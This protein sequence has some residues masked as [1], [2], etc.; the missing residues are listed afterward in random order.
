VRAAPVVVVAVM[1]AASG[2]GLGGT[3]SVTLRARS[4][5]I[6]SDAQP[7][8]L[9][10]ISSG[11]AGE[12][13][14]VQGKECGVPGA[15]FRGIAGAMT[16]EGGGWITDQI[17]QRTTTTYRAVWK[18]S[19]S[20]PLVVRQRINVW[21]IRT[22][23]G[24]QVGVSGEVGNWDRRRVTVQRLTTAGWRRLTSVV[25][26]AQGV[27]SVARRGGLRFSVAKGTLLRAVLPLAQAKPCYLAGYSKLIRA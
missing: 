19:V 17:I 6:R 20:T 23:K 3:G 14:A 7:V 22:G 8:L 12:Y 25:V 27:V 26:R 2:L 11:Q 16:S 24:F 5:V 1:A 10:E 15:F 21:L 4:T 18:D 13:V 9:G